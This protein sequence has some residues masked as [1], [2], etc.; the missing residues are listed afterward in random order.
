MSQ[1]DPAGFGLDGGGGVTRPDEWESFTVWWVAERD[2]QPPT[3]E[4][5]PMTNPTTDDLVAPDEQS[6]FMFDD[7]WLPL[8]DGEPMT[9]SVPTDATTLETVAPF[10]LTWDGTTSFVPVRL[11]AQLPD[12]FGIGVIV[13]ASGSG[14]TTLLRAFGEERR[15]AWSDGAVASQFDS[16]ADAAAR[17]YAVGLNAVPTWTKPYAV[18][19]NGERFRVDL[20]RM[21]DN[22][23]VIDEYTSVVDRNVAMSTSNALRRYV[24]ERGLK[25]IVIAT[26]HRD[27]LPWLQPDWVI[28][29]DI[30][31]W[32]LRPRECLQRP[33]LV[34]TVYAGTA[35]AWHFFHRHHYLSGA[36]NP[37]AHVVIVT[38]GETIV[39]MSAALPFPNGN[40]RNAW[41]EHRTVVLPDFQGLGIGMKL[42]DWVGDY[43]IR[44]GR[45]YF[46]RTAHPRMGG[47]RDASPLWRATSSSRKQARLLTSYMSDDYIAK[48]QRTGWDAWDFDANRVAW[49]HEYVGNDPMVRPPD[50]DPKPV[51]LSF[52]L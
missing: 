26:C 47:Y 49:S 24:G 25:R 3:L 46:S 21:I 4:A 2:K 43:M 14:K 35:D 31:C 44:Q 38:I 5:T 41:R 9:I 48:R 8:P 16:A 37:A 15:P 11:P 51:A 12:D 34:G 13:G 40:L 45:R 33:Q 27:V 6:V 1:E 42:S 36:L 39:A 22:D 30:R 19:S 10:D 20:A 32:S 29:T 23:A 7:A 50:T 18:L 28:D 17:F 52:G